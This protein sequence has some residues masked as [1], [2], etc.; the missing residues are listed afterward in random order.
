MAKRFNPVVLTAN[1]LESGAP[2]WWTGAGW[3]ESFADARVATTPEQAATLQAL[4]D[5]PLMQAATVGPCLVEVV[6]EDGAWRP[7]SRREAIRASR[8]PTFAYGPEAASR[9]GPG[10]R[11]A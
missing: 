4:A 1:A 5:T 6:E 7:A 10:A 11:A 9:R 3:S 2:L 8:S